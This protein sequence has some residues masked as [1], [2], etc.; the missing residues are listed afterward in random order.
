MVSVALKLEK[1]RALQILCLGAHSDD[2]E[3]G[4]GGTISRIIKEHPNAKV[5]W[6]VFGS[7]GIRTTEALNSAN[8]ILTNIIDKKITV[9]GF[10][11]SFFPYTGIEIKEYFEQLKKEMDPDII[12]THYG[13]D[14]HQ[15]HR[16]ISELT[17]NSF[18]NHLIFEYEIPKYDGDMGAP[19]FFVQLNEATAEWKAQHLMSHFKSQAN[20]HWFTKET[21][22][23]LL[24]LRGI[25][26]KAPGNYAEAFFCRK[27]IY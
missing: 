8:A 19:N 18:R 15:D 4:C 5:H 16:L 3:I 14:Y 1:D 9:K 25:E 26:S 13:K 7:T 11:D 21:F 17:W 20:K 10:R 23:A 12:F 27:I 2:I 24:R 22:L 6:V